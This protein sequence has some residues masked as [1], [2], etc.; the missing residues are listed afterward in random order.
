MTDRPK[1]GVSA[2]FLYPDDKRP[3]FAKKTLQL[4]LIHI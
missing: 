1:I 2:C 4:S 3:A